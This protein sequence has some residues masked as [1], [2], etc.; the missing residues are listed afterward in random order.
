MPSLPLL[1]ES[2]AHAAQISSEINMDATSS[3]TQD[4]L[5][6]KKL[7]IM[8]Q[9]YTL[10]GEGVFAGSAAYFIRI[11]GCDVGCH[12]CDVKES[13]DASIHSIQD[14]SDLIRE[15]S[16][17]AEKI[18]ITGGEPL[19]YNLDF[20]C[21]GL[22]KAGCKTHIETSGAH[23]LSGSWDWFCLSPKKNKLPVP[24]AYAAARELK[25]IIYN[26]HDFIFAEEQASLVSGNCRLFLQAEWSR[27][28]EIYP[29]MVEYIK[30]NPK[31]R[32]GLQT[33]KYIHIP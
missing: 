17:Q 12:W 1:S 19:L 16:T 26:R 20:L 6:G 23:P 30:A 24:E 18:I 14:V 11:A 5:S 22:Q 8:E 10:Q 15:A 33:H 27:R 2:F 7:P 9:F 31:W 21:S 29:L 3:L 25:I 13:W 4:I 32:L 28:E